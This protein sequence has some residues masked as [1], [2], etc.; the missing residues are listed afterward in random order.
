MKKSELKDLSE[1][2]IKAVAGVDDETDCKK[3]SC[4]KCGSTNV[5][6]KNIYIHM[7]FSATTADTSSGS[8]VKR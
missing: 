7:F 2:K 1:A 5:I 4:P 8:I 6:E 3:V